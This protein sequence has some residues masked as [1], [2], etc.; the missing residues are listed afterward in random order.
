MAAHPP[1]TQIGLIDG[2]CTAAEPC[3]ALRTNSH[4]T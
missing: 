1:Q 4:R 2:I 3:N